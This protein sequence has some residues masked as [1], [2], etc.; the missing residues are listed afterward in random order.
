[1][2]W[3]FAFA[4]NTAVSLMEAENASLGVLN[5]DS[6]QEMVTKRL[7][8]PLKT[9]WSLG[10]KIYLENH[11]EVP[12][13][14]FTK[15][16]MRQAAARK[17]HITSNDRPPTTTQA[18]LI[19]AKQVTSTSAGFNTQ[20][21]TK[22]NNNTPQSRRD[23][24]QGQPFCSECNTNHPTGS[25]FTFPCKRCGGVAHMWGQHKGH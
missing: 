4:C 8:G 5:E 1:M 3:D 6:T 24:S 9:Q 20:D 12:F 16:I 23:Q 17:N 15:W 22:S 18:T 25:H 7:E 2:L 19:V 13:A 21:K 10:K 11:K 14:N